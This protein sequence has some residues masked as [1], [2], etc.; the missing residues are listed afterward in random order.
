MNPHAAARTSLVGFVTGVVAHRGLITEMTRREVVGRYRGSIA[1]IGWS[2]FNP[3]LML[4]VYSFVFGSIFKLRWSSNIEAGSPEFAIMLFIGMIV[5][6]MFAE[7]ATRSPGL[8]LGNANYVKKVVFP[9][10]VLPVVCVAAAL[11]HAAIS[12]AVLLLAQVVWTGT[13]P[14]TALLLPLI[15]LPFLAALLGLSYWLASLGVFAGDVGQVVGLIV[16]VMLFLS[17]VFYP[18]SALP[19]QY[20]PLLLANPLTFVIEQAR[21]VLF[22]GGLPDLAGLAWYSAASLA[23]LACGFWWFQRTRK[24]FADVI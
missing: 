8:V 24:G 12:V 11:F 7:V 22:T 16:T 2:F 9:L 6:G 23:F 3:L 10:E 15:L 19:Q 21:L 14:G 1:G 18:A 4:L 17:P 13:L 20:R 5:H